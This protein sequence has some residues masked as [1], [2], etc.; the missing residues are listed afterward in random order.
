MLSVD[1]QY[2]LEFRM[3][4]DQTGDTI[5]ELTKDPN[6]SIHQDEWYTLQMIAFDHSLAVYLDESPIYFGEKVD[7][8]SG[9]VGIELAFQGGKGNMDLDNIRLWDLSSTYAAK[10]FAEPIRQWKTVTKPKVY[11]D[12]STAAE[13]WDRFV[14]YRTILGTTDVRFPADV[15]PAGG[16]LSLSTAGS[17]EKQ[18][19]LNPYVFE[20]LPVNDFVLQFDF[21][22][23]PGNYNSYIA[24]QFRSVSDRIH[25]DI[26][27]GRK[28]GLSVSKRE[29]PTDRLIQDIVKDQDLKIDSSLWHTFQLIVFNQTM[30]IYL[31]D[32]PVFYYDQIDFETVEAMW[33]S[34][35]SQKLDIAL[36]NF[37]IWSG[38]Q[39]VTLMD[40]M[41][42]VDVPEIAL[43]PV[44]IG[45]GQRLFE[46]LR[47]PGS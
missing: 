19:Q 25:I 1:P 32:R 45:S 44:L 37:I 11:E 9:G 17:P 15:Q 2:G 16:I 13:Y 34:F 4:N 35:D 29:E 22:P 7:P 24:P 31:D 40:S 43:A 38:Y 6:I 46:N 23:G 33:I 39:G 21:K 14:D 42:M 12:F 18:Y 30:A 5:G 28:G 41:E 27:L 8:R 20:I 3:I 10:P 47:E 36:D 26:G